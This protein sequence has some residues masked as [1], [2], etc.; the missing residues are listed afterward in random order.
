MG[1]LPALQRVRAALN[2]AP[3]SVKWVTPT[4]SPAGLSERASRSTQRKLELSI[5][6]D[7]GF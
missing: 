3:H 6:K 7:S 4:F 5:K 2:V 1:N